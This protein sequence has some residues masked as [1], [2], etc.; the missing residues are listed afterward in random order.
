MVISMSWGYLFM[1][2]PLLAA[3]ASVIGATR[4][5]K[6]ELILQEI[7]GNAFRI[8]LFMFGIYLIL[9]L[10]SWLI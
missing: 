6:P 8:T 9:Q 5:E 10:V 2:V 7:K 3:C 4:H 1:Y